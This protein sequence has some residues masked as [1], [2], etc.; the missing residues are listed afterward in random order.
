MRCENCGF[1]KATG[2]FD[3]SGYTLGIPRIDDEGS[4]LSC[5]GRNNPSKVTK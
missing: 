1:L 2:G 5:N 3:K 4:L